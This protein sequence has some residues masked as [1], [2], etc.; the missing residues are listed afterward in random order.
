LGGEGSCLT[1]ATPTH[2]THQ[3]YVEREGFSR[4]TN[5][6]VLKG[7]RGFLLARYYR[8]PWLSLKPTPARS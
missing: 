2:A 3:T 5:P 8:E 4:A 6:R 7:A 1:H